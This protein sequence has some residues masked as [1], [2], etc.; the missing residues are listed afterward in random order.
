[1]KVIKKGQL[2]KWSK[3]VVCVEE[4]KFKLGCGARLLLTVDDLYQERVSKCNRSPDVF[5]AFQCCECGKETV[6]A[7]ADDFYSDTGIYWND[8]PPQLA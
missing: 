7:E 3:E 2:K 8:L 1:M 5:V 4:E 6:I